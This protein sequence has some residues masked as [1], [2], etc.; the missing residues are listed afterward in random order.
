MEH[1]S[2]GALYERIVKL[3]D[4]IEG[5]SELKNLGNWSIE[6]HTMIYKIYYLDPSGV[7]HV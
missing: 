7:V 5:D 2:R 1:G 3:R 6:N 4:I